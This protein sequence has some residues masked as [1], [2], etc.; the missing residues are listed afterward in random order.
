MFPSEMV[1]LMAIAGVGDFGKTLLM[2]PTDV[3]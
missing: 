1:I 3:M 2:R